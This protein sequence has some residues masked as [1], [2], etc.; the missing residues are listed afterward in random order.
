[1][2]YNTVCTIFENSGNAGNIS[3]TARH[4]FGS[5]YWNDSR[6]QTLTK[7]GVQINDEIAVYLYSFDYIPKAG[8]II[9]KGNAQ[10]E[11]T[12]TQQNSSEIMR[13]LRTAYPDFAYIKSVRDLRFGGL[14][15]IEISAR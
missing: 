4:Y 15:H 11:I 9:V 3:I 1:M 8:D 6:G 7:N 14:P 10:L 13:A 5:A 2:L 12:G